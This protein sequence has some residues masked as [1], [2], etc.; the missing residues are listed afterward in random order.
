MD[1]QTGQRWTA[2]M[3]MGRLPFWIFSPS[4]R[5]AGTTPSDY[6]SALGIMLSREND[7]VTDRIRKDTVLYHR[8]WE[9]L[10]IGALNTEPELASARLLAGLFAQS[11]GAGGE[12]CI[13]L[14]PKIGLSETF[15][16]PCLDLL[17]QHGAEIKYGHRLRTMTLD[18]I[19]IREL[20]FNGRKV[21]IEK[22]DWVVMALPAWVTREFLPEVP[23]P[24]DFRSIISAHFRVDVPAEPLS[25]TGLVGGIA[26]WSFVKN[27]V[28]SV[29]VS[30]A[31]RLA[32]YAVRD[33]AP[34][35]WR[36]VTKLY[37]LDPTKL[38][39]HRIFK[40]KY[41]T[42]AAT[43][44]QNAR[45]PGTFTQWENLALAGEWT[46]TGLPTTIESA[47]RS[48]VKAAQVVMRWS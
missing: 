4:R 27:G 2:R 7:T 20:D 19:A 21:K 36:D 45:R 17:L 24:N 40:E 6:L 18:D 14:I 44:Q 23:T 47:I 29:T 26:E 38:P 43:P 8:F 46:A 11:F 1:L 34:M 31:E 25:F 16:Q 5:V 10:V 33:L 35:I 37:D 41:A 22:D 12:A 42:F 13:P 48:G 28:V 32:E 39:P 30:C 3:N 15:V 9:P